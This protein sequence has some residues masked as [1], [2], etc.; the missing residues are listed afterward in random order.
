MPHIFQLK[1]GPILEETPAVDEIVTL[2]YT[3]ATN[4]Q[5]AKVVMLCQPLRNAV[6]SL[7]L[8]DVNE[9]CQKLCNNSDKNS[10]ILLKLH[11]ISTM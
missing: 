10:S 9:Q 11:T 5:N 2:M 6:K 7:F 8:K 3:G 4:Q 1:D